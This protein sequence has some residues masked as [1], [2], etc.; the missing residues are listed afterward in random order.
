MPPDC[1]IPYKLQSLIYNM[2]DPDPRKRPH[3]I[4]EVRNAL[5]SSSGTLGSMAANPMSKFAFLWP[6]WS[7]LESALAT[8]SYTSHLWLVYLLVALGIIPARHIY[9]LRRLRLLAFP[10]PGVGELLRLACQRILDS[11]YYAIILAF[12]F[13]GI[14]ALLHLSLLAP[15]HWMGGVTSPILFLYQPALYL[16]RVAAF[17]ALVAGSRHGAAAHATAGTAAPV[18][19]HVI[20]RVMSSFA[21]A[22]DDMSESA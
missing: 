22:Q 13:Q 7:L 9:V 16:H 20:P 14:Y 12:F 17:L 19:G 10:A 2:L 21:A 15:W 11:L 3:E 6:V 8:H 5:I 18:T 4:R 1:K